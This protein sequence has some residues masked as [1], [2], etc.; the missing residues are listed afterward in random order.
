MSDRSTKPHIRLNMQGIYWCSDRATLRSGWGATP[1][2]AYREW[3]LMDTG[4]FKIPR[5]GIWARA[6]ARDWWR[7]G[8]PA[9]SYFLGRR[10]I[11]SYIPETDELV[12]RGPA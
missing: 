7:R 10:Q 5:K 1:A 9:I 6:Q 2:A 12:L 11:I 4:R 8:C 3:A